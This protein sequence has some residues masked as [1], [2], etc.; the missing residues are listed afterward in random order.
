MVPAGIFLRGSGPKQLGLALTDDRW[1]KIAV[2]TEYT[3]YPTV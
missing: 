2:I 3:C 1:Q